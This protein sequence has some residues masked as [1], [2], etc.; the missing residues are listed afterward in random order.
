MLLYETRP[1]GEEKHLASMGTSK[2]LGG[3]TAHTIADGAMMQTAG[4]LRVGL[5]PKF[6][7]H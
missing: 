6:Y 7:L 2:Q 4:E 5:V 3:V 1:T